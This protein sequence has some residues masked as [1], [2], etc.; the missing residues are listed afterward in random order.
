MPGKGINRILFPRFLLF[1][2]RNTACGAHKAEK[3]IMDKIL[4]TFSIALENVSILDDALKALREKGYEVEFIR[5]SKYLSE[6]EL[7]AKY[8]GVVAHVAGSDKMTAR[9]LQAADKLKIISRAGVGIETIDVAAATRRGV[10]VTNTP[11]AGAETVAEFAFA[12]LISVSRRVVEVHTNLH[13]EVWK[14]LHGYSLYRKTLGV[15]GLGNIGKQLIKITRGFD[16]KPIACDPYPDEQYAKE[17]GIELVEFDELLKRSDYISVH[18]PASASTMDLIGEKEL[19]R[20]K[21]TAIIV[22]TSRGGIINEKALYAALKEKTIWG[23]GLDVH[24]VEPMTD[25]TNPLLTLDNIVT[26]AHIAGASEEGRKKVVEMA[27]QNTLDF[28]EGRMPRG[29]INPE[30]LE[31]RVGRGFV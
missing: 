16:M 24:T 4:F 6:D 8:P 17:H 22:N 7:A 12:L 10:L 23:A 5:V 13:K 14:R 29:M 30:V 27:I 20:M 21:P 26:T 2:K 9:A 15:I 31:K 18:V 25:M 3:I 1:Q 11:G 19:S 28:L